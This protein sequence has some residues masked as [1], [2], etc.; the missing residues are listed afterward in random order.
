MD[1]GFWQIYIGSESKNLD[2]AI[3][4][5]YKEI[6]NHCDQRIDF[7]SIAPCERTVK[8][9]FSVRNGLKFRIDARFREKY[10]GVQSSGHHSR[11]SSRNR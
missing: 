5:I 8:R 11:N 9:T 1:T 4:L 3:E 7:C 6:K 2:K 10:A